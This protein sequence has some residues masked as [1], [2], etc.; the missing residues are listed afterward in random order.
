[1]TAADQAEA[2]PPAVAVKALTSFVGK[3]GASTAVVS[4]L[5]QRGARIVLVGAD[6]TWGDLVVA[7]VAGG[8]AACAA[9]G[10]TVAEKW[11]RE[12]TESVRTSGVEWG[13]MGRG[14]PVRTA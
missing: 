5:G 7:E 13:R 1:M 10:V 14:R 6:G 4:Y 11:S 9:A 2:A 8:T 3:H 12:L